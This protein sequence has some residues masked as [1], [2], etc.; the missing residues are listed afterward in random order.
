MSTFT[1]AVAPSATLKC[2]PT[3]ESTKYGEG[4][5]QRTSIGINSKPRKWSVRVNKNVAAALNFLETHNGE[6]S[7]MWTDPLGVTSMYLCREWTCNHVGAD[8][9]DIS[10]DFEQVFE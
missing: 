10:C 9:F 2:K 7:F 3:V 8:I 6:K 5:E 4:Y 1:W